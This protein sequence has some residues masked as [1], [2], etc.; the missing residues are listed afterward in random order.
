MAYNNIYINQV[1]GVLIVP[2]A[3]Y[4]SDF[5]IPKKQR[6]DISKGK[7]AEKQI[8]DAIPSLSPSPYIYQNFMPLKGSNF[9]SCIHNYVTLYPIY[10]VFIHHLNT[11]YTF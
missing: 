9:V 7:V 4:M 8:I 11:L 10:N 1:D 6:K 2:I 3:I 5:S